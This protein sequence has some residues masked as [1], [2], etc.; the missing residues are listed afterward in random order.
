MLLILLVSE[1][2]GWLTCAWFDFAEWDGQQGVVGAYSACCVST[3]PSLS[4]DCLSKP[5]SLS[6]RI[7]FPRCSV[8]NAAEH[9][10]AVFVAYRNKVDLSLAVSI[11]SSIQIA[12][13]VIPLLVIIS[14][15][16]GKPLSLL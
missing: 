9:V 16:I 15:A 2:R 7:D 14:W 11:G 3:P 8:G 13:F 1:W 10:T 4:P 6:H 12:L 5:I